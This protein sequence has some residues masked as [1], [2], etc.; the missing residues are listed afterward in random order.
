MSCKIALSL[1]HLGCFLFLSQFF[2]QPL[3]ARESTIEVFILAGQ[4]NMEGH[5]L[6]GE[7]ADGVN[8]S[9][10]YAATH[11]TPPDWPSCTPAEAAANR[12]G[13]D[14]YGADFSVLLDASGTNWTTSSS[15]FVDCERTTRA[16]ASLLSRG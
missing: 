7:F 13:C 12:M 14:A 3:T 6:V 4:S 15:V 8:G 16:G 1:P 10:A 9:L 5:G 11:A 2:P